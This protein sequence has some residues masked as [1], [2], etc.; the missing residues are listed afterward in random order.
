MIA[1]QGVFKAFRF[2]RHPIFQAKVR[3]EL[4]MSYVR[5]VSR[6]TQE[7]MNQQRLQ[8]SL[9]LNEYDSLDETDHALMAKTIEAMKDL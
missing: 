5:P 3:R 6:E 9:S 8:L 4:A 7:L 1:I 2:V